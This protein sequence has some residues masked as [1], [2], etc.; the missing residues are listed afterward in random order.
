M[1]D[2][3]PAPAPTEAAER[4]ISIHL[5]LFG[6]SPAF[7]RRQ[8]RVF[9]IACTAGFFDNYDRA[10]LGLALQQIQQGL[11]IAEN[12]LGD[13]LSVI[14]LG[15]LLSLLLTPFSDVF[16]R[17]RLLLYTIYGYTIFTALSAVAPGPGTFMTFQVLAR[18]F[19]GAEA[20]VALV[21]L[22]EE[23]DAGVRGWTVGLL[24]ALASVGYGIAALAFAFIFHIPYG[25]RGLYALA[26]VPLAIIIPLRRALP[27]SHRFEDTAATPAH[28]TTMLAPVAALFRAYP[29]RL[30]MMLVVAFLGNL[31]GNAAGILF[32]KYLQQAHGYSPANVSTLF[33]VGGAV[34]ILG[35]IIVGRMSDKI[36]RRRAGA[37]C[38][39]A[40]PILTVWMYSAHGWSV[41][42]AWILE[43]FFDTASGTI[44]A[45]YSAE[46]F[47][48]SHRTTAG[49]ALSVAGTTGGALG[50][51]LES[52]LYN[53][54]GS[55]WIAVRYLTV[56]WMI[57]PF[58]MYL[59]YPETAGME[60]ESISPEEPH[61]SG[62]PGN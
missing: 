16:G 25:W 43:L 33:F 23:V 11:R 61:K 59:F 49:S 14:R 50:L 8:W 18:A 19:A 29:R 17:R 20:T 52:V 58:V 60:L 27:E 26:L 4:R 37:V 28:P 15:Y 1:S 42:P 35:S 32:P 57:A 38:F 53:Y 22:T 54:T 9:L 24:S 10:L 5:G 12:R 51:A 36:G 45:A 47:P 6:R 40:A 48:T 30:A 2:S 44:L 56:F 21:I 13:V 41:I 46:L 34:G 62:A 31:G 3:Q 39:L 55:H 7:T